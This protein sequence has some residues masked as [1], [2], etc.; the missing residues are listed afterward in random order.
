MS[1]DDEMKVTVGWAW[2]LGAGLLGVG[3]AG[4]LLYAYY[5]N[6]RLDAQAPI[7]ETCVH[8]RV[9]QKVMVQDL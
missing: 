3:L 4:M 2:L 6:K 8:H 1:S 5:E 9:N 7:V